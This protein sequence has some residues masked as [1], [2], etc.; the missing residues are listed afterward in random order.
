MLFPRM[1]FLRDGETHLSAEKVLRRAWQGV[2]VAVVAA[3]TLLLA[4][5]P[6][7]PA[8][9]QRPAALAGVAAQGPGTPAPSPQPSAASAQSAAQPSVQSPATAAV[10]D[11]RAA[12]SRPSPPTRQ[13][14]FVTVWD[15][16][17]GSLVL[18]PASGRQEVL[19]PEV[20][21]SAVLFGDSQ[22]AG[23]QGVATGDTWVARGLAAQGYTVRFVGAGGIGFTARTAQ[24][25]NYVDSLVSGQIK[26]PYGNPALVVVQGGG[27]DAGTGASDAAILANAERLLRELKASYPTSKYLFIG[28]LAR[29]TPE[30]ARRT[31]VDALVGGFAQRNGASFI[32]AGDW[33]T[34]YGVANKMADGVHM[35]A[36]GH[37]D[38]GRV[39]ATQLERRGLR[40]PARKG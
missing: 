36:A 14:E 37:Q 2:G 20:A 38:L 25:G 21:R 9:S 33:L 30:S 12:T 4:N 40:A 13:D 26:L 29:G 39:L 32:G 28:T 16:P 3:L 18:N 17:P 10:M 1:G 7:T 19:D 35:N 34:R 5:P 11:P 22:S 8:P 27:N 24:S 15:L 23:G 6:G 31:A